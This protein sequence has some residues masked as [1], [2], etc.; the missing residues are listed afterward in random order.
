[1]GTNARIA[2]LDR[3]ERKRPR[4]DAFD[5]A[6]RGTGDE[7][8]A[9]RHRL[10]ACAVATADEIEDLRRWPSEV[11]AARRA[12]WQTLRASGTDFGPPKSFVRLQVMCKSFFSPPCYVV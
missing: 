8:N 1:M 7:A 11:E 5:A 2:V 6:G 4:L 12:I 10:C 3:G 9:L